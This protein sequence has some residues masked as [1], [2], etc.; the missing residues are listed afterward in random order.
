[1]RALIGAGGIETSLGSISLEVRD[2]PGVGRGDGVPT[3]Y[4]LRT[5]SLPSRHKQAEAMTEATDL[6]DAVAAMVQRW[7]MMF[8]LPAP[9]AGPASVTAAS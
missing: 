2:T 8:P 4:L 6:V 3:A 1:M 7:F 9:S 5:T